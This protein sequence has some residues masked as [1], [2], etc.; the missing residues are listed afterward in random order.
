[1]GFVSRIFYRIDGRI[2]RDTERELNACLILCIR[3]LGPIVSTIQK[4]L[5]TYTV[6]PVLTYHCPIIK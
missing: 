4:P 6:T 5:G 2:E 1:M 3:P